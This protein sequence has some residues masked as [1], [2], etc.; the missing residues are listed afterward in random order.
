MCSKASGFIIRVGD[1]YFLATNWHVVTGMNFFSG[2]WISEEIYPYK[3]K[4]HFPSGEMNPQ[5]PGYP[6]KKTETKTFSLYDDQSKPIWIQ[7]K[8][9]AGRTCNNDQGTQLAILGNDV[10]LLQIDRFGVDENVFEFIGTNFV[11]KDPR[12][13]YMSCVLPIGTQVFIV[14][15]PYGYNIT[16]IDEIIQPI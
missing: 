9:G 15:Y 3:L 11:L 12:V 1:K 7:D 14:G 13:S 4:V 16:K 10:V 5:A 6:I 8:K 2:R